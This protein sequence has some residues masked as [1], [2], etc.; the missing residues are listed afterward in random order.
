MKT[1]AGLA[2]KKAEEQK[3]ATQDSDRAWV[4]G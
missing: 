4:K 1:G 2:E 3:K